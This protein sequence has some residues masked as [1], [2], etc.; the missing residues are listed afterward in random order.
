MSRSTQSTRARACKK[1]WEHAEYEG[2]IAQAGT[3]LLFVIQRQRRE[4]SR[5]AAG[6]GPHALARGTPC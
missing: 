4:T 6:P 5:C 1:V 3:C 2:A